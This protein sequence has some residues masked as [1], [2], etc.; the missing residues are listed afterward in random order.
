MEWGVFSNDATTNFKK[1]WNVLLNDKKGR[2]GWMELKSLSITTCATYEP[3]SLHIKPLTRNYTRND[4]R[5]GNF[6]LVSVNL[7]KIKVYEDEK[8]STRKW[9]KNVIEV[10][11]DKNL[12]IKNANKLTWTKLKVFFLLLENWALKLGRFHSLFKNWENLRRKTVADDAH[13]SCPLCLS[14]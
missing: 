10:K 8:K 11:K 2:L 13:T 14:L 4:R 3:S 1:T 12:S 9:T 5:K 7:I 6:F